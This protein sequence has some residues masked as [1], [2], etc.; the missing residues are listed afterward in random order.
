MKRAIKTI[1]LTID[2]LTHLLAIDDPTIRQSI[3]DA[4]RTK[5]VDETAPI[6][7]PSEPMIECLVEKIRKKRRAAERRRQARERRRLEGAERC[8]TEDDGNKKEDSGSEKTVMFEAGV[9]LLEL[10]KNDSPQMLPI[11]PSAV[12]KILNVVYHHRSW[13]DNFFELFDRLPESSA[14]GLLVKQTKNSIKHL[15]SYI[16]KLK[17]LAQKYYSIPL[18]DRPSEVW[19]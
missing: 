8:C 16:P 9:S 19:L 13:F 15:E 2:E 10:V 4:V 11:N 14:I 5:A 1:S 18:L 17:V 3:A 6:E 12:T 7:N